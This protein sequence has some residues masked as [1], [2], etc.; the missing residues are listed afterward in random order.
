M[1][2]SLSFLHFTGLK[3]AESKIYSLL[4]PLGRQIKGLAVLS[5]AINN[6]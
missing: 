1:C 6:A 2:I 3:T 5:R 4:E